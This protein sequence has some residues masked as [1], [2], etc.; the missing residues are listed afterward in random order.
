MQTCIGLYLPKPLTQNAAGSVETNTVS[1][2]D[3]DFSK[4]VCLSK[5]NLSVI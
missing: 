4:A 2:D 3:R 1:L 5:P